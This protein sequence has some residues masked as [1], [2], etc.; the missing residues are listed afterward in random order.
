VGGDNRLVMI[1]DTTNWTLHKTLSGHEGS[2][3][4]LQ[5]SP[6]GARIASG[7]GTDKD[8]I[9]NIPENMIKIWDFTTG[10]AM[11]NLTGHTDGVMDVKWSSNGSRL[12]SAS[13]DRTI[14]MWNTSTW[15]NVF[16]IT[17]H[18]IG[19]LS[20]DWSPNETKLVSGSRDYSVMLWDASNGSNLAKWS[21]PNCVRSVDWHPDAD[22]IAN[23]GPAESLMRVR[24]STSGAVIKTFDEAA[25]TGSDVMSTRWSP[26]GMMLAAGAGKEHTLRVYAFGIATEPP[27]PL[28]PVWLPGTILFSAISTVGAGLIIWQVVG[29]LRI[30]IHKEG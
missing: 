26:D 28:I 30:R 11:A 13:D 9:H 24:N 3:L 12:V 29:N 5:W 1:Y 19:V 2:V 23:S 20:V 15:S 6:D 18:T 25:K 17:G 8:D 10:N 14:K 7:S 27:P 4:A 16:D 22:L 21:S